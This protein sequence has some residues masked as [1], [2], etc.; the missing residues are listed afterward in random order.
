MVSVVEVSKN[1]K[2]L[3]QIF[4][5]TPVD[6]SWYPLLQHAL[7][8]L[9]TGYIEELALSSDNWLPGKNAIF[10]A[11]S[12]PLS[13]TQ[14]ILFGESPYPRP[15]SANGYAFW[16]GRVKNIWSSNG[17]SKEVNRATSLRNIIKMLLVSSNILTPAQCTQPQISKINK[18]YLI[19]DLND[20][21]NNLLNNGF[22]LLNASLVLSQR[23]VQHDAKA[24]L[25]VI[26]QLLLQVFAQRPSIQLI[27]FG[28]IA[29]TINTLPIAHNFKQIQ[30]EHP[31]NI[32]FIQN[33]TII[34]FFR[35]FNL[36]YRE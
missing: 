7:C 1:S 6:K 30:S 21:F 18:T 31:Y 2:S 17:L 32:S 25:P 3:T 10:N 16:D 34:E 11:F 24:W 23:K 28:K 35:Q 15:E 14:Y 13:Q 12:L 8:Y 36:L 22:L 5:F 33:S 27:L 20:L 4:S 19:N 9:P 26:E 29:Q